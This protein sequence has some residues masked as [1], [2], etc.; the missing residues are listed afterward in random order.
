MRVPAI[1]SMPGTLPEG[2]TNFD[3]VSALDLYRTFAE[4]VGITV[5]DREAGDSKSFAC[6]FNNSCKASPEH[7]IFYMYE[8]QPMA[9]R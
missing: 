8:K 9:V 6:V 2:A 4:M 7:E 5:P 1:F 3:V